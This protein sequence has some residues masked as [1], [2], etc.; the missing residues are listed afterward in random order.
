MKNSFQLFLLERDDKKDLGEDREVLIRQAALSYG[1][2]ENE[3][4]SEKILRS[5]NGKPFFEKLDIHFSISH[6]E[7]LWA[8]LMGPFNCGLD[9]QYVKPCNFAKIAGR[10]FSEREKEYV[11]RSG[12]DG[13]FD[14]WVRRE[15]FGKYTGEGFFGYMPEFITEE[16]SLAMHLAVPYR[17]IRSEIP[18]QLETPVQFETQVRIETLIRFETPFVGDNIKCAV[19]IPAEAGGERTDGTE[20]GGKARNSSEPSVNI[21]SDWKKGEKI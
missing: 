12:L 15:A 11:K 17:E 7:S 8:C 19:C 13:F 2:S 3:L 18:I 1:V 4:R 21:V 16:N 10:F 5:K 6:S 9:V 20:A 14:I